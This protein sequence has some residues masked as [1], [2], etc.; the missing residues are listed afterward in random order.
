MYSIIHADVWSKDKRGSTTHQFDSQLIYLTDQQLCSPKKQSSK[1]YINSPASPPSPPSPSIS[2][3]GSTPPPH[4]RHRSL[5][6][7]LYSCPT[8]TQPNMQLFSWTL[9]CGE[10]PAVESRPPFYSPTCV[11]TQRRKGTWTTYAAFARPASSSMVC[12]IGRVLVQPVMGAWRE[13]V[14][15]MPRAIVEYLRCCRMRNSAFF[16]LS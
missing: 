12:F 11:R 8:Q 16:V 5:I 6:L 3:S 14:Y 10:S 4:L 1:Q 2:S 15:E 13:L 9:F 7:S